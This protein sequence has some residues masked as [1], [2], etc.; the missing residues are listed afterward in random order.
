MEE[1]PDQDAYSPGKAL[2]NGTILEEIYAVQTE[3]HIRIPAHTP[4]NND[5]ELVEET[6]V[7]PFWWICANRT[8]RCEWIR[9]RI[10]EHAEDELW[11]AAGY[12]YSQKIA[13]EALKD[14]PTRTMDE[15]IP[16]QY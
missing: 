10:T 3:N 14:R 13:E 2:S 11:C 5:P 16:P 4:S 9:L 8:A 15:M 7:T 1:I 6:L 12:T